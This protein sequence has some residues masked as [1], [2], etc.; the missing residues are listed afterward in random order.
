[1]QYTGAAKFFQRKLFPLT[2]NGDSYVFGLAGHAPN[3][4]MAIDECEEALTALGSGE[5]TLSAVKKTIRLAVK[6][7]IDDYVLSRPEAERSAL[8]FELLVGCWIPDGGASGHR[9][10]A[11]RRNGAV[12]RIEGYECIGVGSYLGDFLIAPAFNHGLS[13]G[14]IQLLAAQVLRSAKS[15]DANC[16]GQSAFEIIHQDGK[17]EPVFFD[18]YHAD[19]FFNTH[20]VLAKSLLFFVAPYNTDDL[21]FDVKLREFTETMKSIRSSW[22]KLH[23]SQQNLLMALPKERD[24]ILD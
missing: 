15:Y 24:D 12:N 18:F 11:V 1:M 17:R 14:T 22:K 13:L 8:D 19:L 21:L 7:V 6:P 4:K 2:I 3:G 5:R 10:L 23:N 9:L 20:E 16:G